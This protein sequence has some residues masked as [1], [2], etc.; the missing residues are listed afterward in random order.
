[1]TLH[2]EGP[3]VVAG[4]RVQIVSYVQFAELPGRSIHPEPTLPGKPRQRLAS[5]KGVSPLLLPGQGAVWSQSGSERWR[6][7]SEP[8]NTRPPRMNCGLPRSFDITW[9]GAQRGISV[10]GWRV[11]DLT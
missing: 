1:M 3:Q 10:R 8:T 9:G 7:P 2:T 11:A 6:T 4:P 5:S